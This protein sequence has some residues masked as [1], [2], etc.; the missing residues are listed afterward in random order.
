MSSSNEYV[1]EVRAAVMRDQGSPLTI[2]TVKLRRVGSRDV[3]V[4][5]ALTGVCHSDLSLARGPLNQPAP[6]VLGHEASGVVVEVGEDVTKV[7]VGQ[8]V[9]LLWIPPCEECFFCRNG[10][11]YLCERAAARAEDPYAIDANGDPIFPGLSVGSFAEETVV[12]ENGVVAIPDTITDGQAA[13]LGCAVTAGVG[14]VRNT[15]RVEPGSSVL[16]IGL[17]GV[18][19][20]AIQGARLSGA[21]TII[22]VDRRTDKESTARRF[23]ATHFLA[24]DTEKFSKEVRA[25][26][27]GR[28]ADYAFDCVG[29]SATTTL[30]W[31]S[32]R[33]GGT[34]CIVGIGALDDLVTFNS[35][36]LF[37]QARTLVGTVAGS[38]EPRTGLQPYFDWIA[39]D[40]LD[41]AAMVSATEPLDQINAAFD[42]IARGEGLRTL[43]D[44]HLTSS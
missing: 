40:R 1:T 21:A 10:E 27:E 16:V 7:E 8:R 4:R 18:G 14:A 25:L 29:S 42:R 9:I 12:P 44:P 17:G 22:G 38:H 34:T 3:R 31:R 39:D 43:L 26:T 11:S 15:A 2:E 30:A 35:L 23:G 28:G 13:L 32:T 24:A 41:L 6:A 33:R 36:E 5:I 19:M 20:S 37:H